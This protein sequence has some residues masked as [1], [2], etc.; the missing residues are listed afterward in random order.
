MAVQKQNF[1]FSYYKSTDEFSPKCA[2]STCKEPAKHKVLLDPKNSK[3]TVYMCLGHATAHNKAIDYFKNMGTKEIEEEL[4][5]DTIWRLPTWPLRGDYKRFLLEKNIFDLFEESSAS[6]QESLKTIAVP[7][8]IQEAAH[9]IGVSFPLEM[10]ELKK[11]YK[12][13]VK[14]LHPDLNRTQKGTEEE[15]KKINIAYKLLSTYLR[16][17]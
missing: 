17:A 10:S 8:N 3:E 4:K 15:L 12:N 9:V 6:H 13:K 11:I 1:N 7:S 2:V 5:A 14:Q 16:D